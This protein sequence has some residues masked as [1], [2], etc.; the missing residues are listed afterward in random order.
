MDLN[1]PS[2]SSPSPKTPIDTSNLNAWH[3]PLAEKANPTLA[4]PS[5]D[6]YK[7]SNAWAQQGA[8]QDTVPP[9]PDTSQDDKIKEILDRQDAKDAEVSKSRIHA[10][11]ERLNKI[12]KVLVTHAINRGIEKE[13]EF[14][15]AKS[16]FDN[17]TKALEQKGPDALAHASPEQMQLLD[18][19]QNTLLAFVNSDGKN[20]EKFVSQMRTMIGRAKSVPGSGKTNE[21][22]GSLSQSL[23]Q[24]S[25]VKPKSLFSIITDKYFGDIK[26]LKTGKDWFDEKSVIGQ[27]LRRDN[28]SMQS[29]VASDI[30]SGQLEQEQENLKSETG[31][32]K[33]KP[34]SA[35]TTSLIQAKPL[36]SVPEME[37]EK[38]STTSLIQAKPLSSVPEMEKE[39]ASEESHYQEHVKRKDKASILNNDKDDKGIKSISGILGKMLIE[40][41][42]IKEALILGELGSATGG[43]DSSSLWNKAKNLFKKG[44]PASAGAVGAGSTGMMLGTVGSVALGG[45]IASYGATGI[46]ASPAQEANR[47]ALQDNS[48]LGAT[49]GDTAMA[50][51]ILDAN[52]GKAPEQIRAEQAKE[53]AQLKDAPWYTR[54]YGIGKSDYI[55]E[56]PD[57][58]LNK[59]PDQLPALNEAQKTQDKAPVVIQAPASGNPAP[60]NNTQTVPV[61]ASSR[62]NDSS[63]QDWVKHKMQGW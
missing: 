32:R 38:A 61:R 18:K 5:S 59:A 16:T 7:P 10:R 62:N 27:Y 49:S 14:I 4:T 37:K 29:N 31:T 60:Q 17:F 13:P 11:V 33:S 22:L 2:A 25:P 8:E 46:R 48:M 34:Y 53:K 23:S 55:K 42:D 9:A 54:I 24:G 28:N 52:Q 56:H 63:F 58:M 26:Q 51:A 50:S 41:Q 12:G 19:I 21:F 20:Y 40:L 1:V 35:S 43:G 36:S 30:S 39:K 6:K 57:T 47:K 44:A 3:I 45:A 15:G